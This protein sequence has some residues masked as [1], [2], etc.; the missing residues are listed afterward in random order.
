MDVSLAER[1]NKLPPYI[2]A[3]MER[4]ILEKKR[5]GVRMISLS[6]GDPDLPPPPFILDSLREEA[7]NPTNHN[8]SLSQ[9]EPSFRDAVAGWYKFRFNVDL[10]GEKEVIALIGSKEESRTSPEPS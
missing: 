8:Y 6:I 2:F 10:D 7:G 9:G 3:E 1:V 5:Q 4:I